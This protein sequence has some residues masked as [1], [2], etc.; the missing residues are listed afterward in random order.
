M[1]MLPSG[2]FHDYHKFEKNRFSNNQNC[3]R[4]YDI[5]ILRKKSKR[6]FSK[7]A[8]NTQL[9]IVNY[10]I[11]LLMGRAG[12][13]KMMVPSLWRELHTE[14][15]LFYQHYNF[16]KSGNQPSFGGKSAQKAAPSVAPQ[17]Q[18]VKTLTLIKNPFL[19]LFAKSVRGGLREDNS[20]SSKD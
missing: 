9:L 14:T 4:R 17:K 10:D 19:N 6:R 1:Q 2:V 12:I 20:I 3:H 11:Q 5:P 8:R 13:H 18:K 15:S 16:A 7:E